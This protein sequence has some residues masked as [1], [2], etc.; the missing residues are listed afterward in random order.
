MWWVCQ[1]V[2]FWLHHST[3]SHSVKHKLDVTAHGASWGSGVVS[4][5]EALGWLAW[6]LLLHA[7]PPH[8]ATPQLT[9]SFPSS[10]T[11]SVEK[12]WCCWIA[13]SN[14]AAG[15]CHCGP[16]REPGADPP[17]NQ[18]EKDSMHW[19][20]VW[21]DNF[22]PYNVMYAVWWWISHCPWIVCK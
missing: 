19:Y 4:D 17:T 15:S 7:G 14:L 20:L 1:C 8:I 13:D 18:C 9:P 5:R 22:C 12:C 16:I 6:C 21:R 3:R 10:V 2:S 11:V